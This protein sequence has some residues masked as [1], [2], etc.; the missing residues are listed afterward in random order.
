VTPRYAVTPH[1][2]LAGPADAPV[3]VLGNSLGTDLSMWD[4]VAAVLDGQFRLLRFDHRGHG[5]SPVLPGPYEIEDL[6]RDLLAL[7]DTVGL[8]RVSYCGLSLGGM[9]GMW[10][11][12]RAPERVDRLALCCTS[13]WL[14]PA[15]G[16]LDR[17]A[18]VRA[19]GTAAVA[20]AVLGRWFST[21]WAAAHPAEVER[22]R[23]MLVGV[24]PEGY[25]GCCEAIASMDL[26]ADLPS[27]AAETLVLAGGN[28][29]ATPP[30]HGAAIAAAVPRARLV[31]LPQPAHLAAVE[32]PDTVA[33]LL[34][35]HLTLPP[36]GP[37][38]ATPREEVR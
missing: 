9:V 11:A 18:R 10:L 1:H 33:R 29:V 13:A 25:A 34:L 14:P 36:P 2:V 35:D 32:Q 12:A 6:G 20:D 19:G 5:G 30:S 8:E 37:S 15:E 21:D 23:A 7:L 38:G 22:A 26:R 31:L 28:D 4:G 3:L 16:W 27:I 17:A 24:P